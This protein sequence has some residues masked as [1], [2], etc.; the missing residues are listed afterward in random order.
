MD[1]IFKAEVKHTVSEIILDA[2]GFALTGLVGLVCIALVMDAY[3]RQQTL[4]LISILTEDTDVVQH[5]LGNIFQV[6]FQETPWQYF[7]AAVS[8]VITF[9][10]LLH[11]FIKG[12]PRLRNRIRAINKHRMEK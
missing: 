4:E 3:F 5:E 11:I 10:V 8:A 1:K 12:L 2:I 7:I 6:L 9:F